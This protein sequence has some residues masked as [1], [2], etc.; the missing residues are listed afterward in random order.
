[1]TSE[2]DNVRY[3]NTL[4]D[5]KLHSKHTIQQL[6][7]QKTNNL[8]LQKHV[9]KLPIHSKQHICLNGIHSLHLSM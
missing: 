9:H 6:I 4:V 3:V 8:F 5:K 1:M 7:K 2:I